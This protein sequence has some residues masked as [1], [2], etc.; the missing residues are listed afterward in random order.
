MTSASVTA[1]LLI[2][3][4]RRCQCLGAGLLENPPRHFAAHVVVDVHLPN[5]VDR[6]PQPGI[7]NDAMFVVWPVGR[8][9][10]GIAHLLVADRHR[11]LPLKWH[12]HDARTKTRAERSLRQAWRGFEA[13]NIPERCSVVVAVANHAKPEQME[14]CAMVQIAP[15]R[16]H[17]GGPVAL[18]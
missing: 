12:R 6:V 8:R 17:R 1:P 9:G 15:R 5:S 18:L 11:N 10:R 13:Y 14:G 7:G 3:F 4:L 16:A 2:C